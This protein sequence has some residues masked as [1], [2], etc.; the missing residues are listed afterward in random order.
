MVFF[1][2]FQKNKGQDI[3]RG[4][5]VISQGFNKQTAPSNIHTKM[6]SWGG[7][8]VFTSKPHFTILLGVLKLKSS[9]NPLI[10]LHFLS[11]SQRMRDALLQIAVLFFSDFNLILAI[12]FMY[13]N[14]SNCCVVL[15]NFNLIL[16][17][18]Q[19]HAQNISNC[20]VVLFEF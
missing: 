5:L 18:L 10:L 2:A 12:C 16:I 7:H 19:L 1:S 17:I 14:I 13:R 3:Y 15:S 11:A 8:Y 4:V 20:F 6:D 9:K